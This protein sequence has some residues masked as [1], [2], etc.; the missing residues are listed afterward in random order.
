MSTQPL[1][2]KIKEVAQLLGMSEKWVYQNQTQ[3]AGYL[4]IGKAILFNREI[5]LESLKP[6]ATKT[7]RSR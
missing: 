6:K 1:T 4:K 2:I 3:I 5:F 7:V